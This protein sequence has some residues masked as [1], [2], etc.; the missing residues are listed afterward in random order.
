VVVVVIAVVPL[1]IIPL[2]YYIP[3][4]ACFTLVQQ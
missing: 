2:F 4:L 1:Y 3:F